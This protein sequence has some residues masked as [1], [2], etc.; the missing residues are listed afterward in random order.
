MAHGLN[1]R[2]VTAFLAYFDEQM[3]VLE[4]LKYMLAGQTVRPP[5]KPNDENRSA[6]SSK[7]KPGAAK[8][9]VTSVWINV[10]VGQ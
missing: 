2:G 4:I 1:E 5:A 8:F 7:I 10:R 3:A 9:S 6:V